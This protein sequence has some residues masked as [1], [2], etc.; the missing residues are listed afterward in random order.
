MSSPSSS[1]VAATTSNVA[2]ITNSPTTVI[3]SSS[4][5]QQTSLAA[6][7]LKSQ[8]T[9]AI[10][11]GSKLRYSCVDCTSW[12]VALG[13]NTGS[14][15][16]FDPDT[17]RLLTLISDK[18]L[19]EPIVKLRISPPSSM[20]ASGGGVIAVA[21]A[22][23]SLFLME[24]NMGTKKER[25]RILHRFSLGASNV[26]YLLWDDHWNLFIGDESGGVWCCSLSEASRR[27]RTYSPELLFRCDSFVVQLSLAN[28]RLLASSNS[29]CMMLDLAK[30]RATIV[31]ATAASATNTQVQQQQQAPKCV[32]AVLLAFNIFSHLRD[33]N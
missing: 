7:P 31:A 28:D 4:S 27:P 5:Q 23:Q 14:M 21:T 9:D 15:Y 16:L 3:Q 20:F 6:L 30:Y 2:T 10:K 12:A 33:L 13:T 22:K 17:L 19:R 29:R 26:S 24:V 8:P 1:S 11:V 32:C 25:E 18:D